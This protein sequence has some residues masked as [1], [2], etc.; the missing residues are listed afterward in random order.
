MI[1]T[2]IYGPISRYSSRVDIVG[3]IG[4]LRAAPTI[5]LI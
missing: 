4:N 1:N 5:P 2:A 3:S